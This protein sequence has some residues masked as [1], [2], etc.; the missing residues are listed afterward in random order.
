MPRQ[1]AVG[2]MDLQLS[3]ARAIV[4]ASSQGIGLASAKAL[5][6]EGAR[7]AISSRN[8]ANLREAKSEIVE[9]TAAEP[10]DVDTFTC[11]LSEPDRV[12]ECIKSDRSARWA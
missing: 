5:A 6:D 1:T 8:Q 10:E 3:E 7:V 12:G 9:E 2:V 4:L 11:D